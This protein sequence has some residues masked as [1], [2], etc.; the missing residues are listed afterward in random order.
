MQNCSVKHVTSAAKKKRC[1]QHKN[2]CSS[3]LHLPSPPPSQRSFSYL[4]WLQ[5]ELESRRRAVRRNREQW[6]DEQNPI[7]TL[8]SWEEQQRRWVKTWTGSLGRLPTTILS[9]LCDTPGETGG[10]DEEVLDCAKPIWDYK[11]LASIFHHILQPRL[12][13]VFFFSYADSE[14]TRRSAS[15]HPWTNALLLTNS[16]GEL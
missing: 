16:C 11:L 13:E 5:M 7:S 8:V 14:K 12:S 15:P 2:T 10:V 1:I 9:N 4:S 3:L 6:E